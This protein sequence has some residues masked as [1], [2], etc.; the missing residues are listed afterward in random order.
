[1]CSLHGEVQPARLSW[2]PQLSSEHRGSN[3]SEPIHI[4]MSYVLFIRVFIGSLDRGHR[5]LNNI[6][7]AFTSRS[8]FKILSY[9][10][11]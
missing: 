1:M 11:H 8:K 3:P 2:W 9:M 10:L 7:N 6:L 4:R 5:F